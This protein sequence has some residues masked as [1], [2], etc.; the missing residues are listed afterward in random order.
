M[1]MKTIRNFFLTVFLCLALACVSCNPSEINPENPEDKTEDVGPY[2]AVAEFTVPAGVRSVYVEYPNASGDTVFKEVSV[3]PVVAAP[4]GG[5]D[6]EPFG[7]VKLQVVSE[8]K[9][10]ASIY[11]RTGTPTKAADDDDKVYTVESLQVTKHYSSSAP[12][13]QTSVTIEE[14]A[15]YTTEDGG[16]SFYHSSGVVMFDDSWPGAP[17][18]TTGFIADYNDVVVDYDFEARI[19]SDDMLAEEGWREQLKVVLHIRAVGGDRPNRVGLIMENFDTRY[20]D[21]NDIELHKSLD[22]YMNPHGELPSSF[23]RRIGQNCIHDESNPTRPWIEI[24]GLHRLNQNLSE[25]NLSCEEYTYTNY[26][27]NG[28][29]V[30]TKHVFNPSFGYWSAPDQSQYDPEIKRKAQHYYNAIPGYVNVHGGL[31]TITVIYHKLPR[32]EMSPEESEAAKQNMIDAVM[33]TTNQNFYI[34]IM[35]YSEIGL[36]GYQP[37]DSFKS[38]YNSVVAGSSYLTDSNYYTGSDGQVWG[39]KAPVMT[40]H[41]WEKYPLSQAYPQFKDW[42]AGD[43]AASGWYLNYDSKYLCCEW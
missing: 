32:A 17:S 19:A 21:L 34:M 6:V 3:T 20:I 2:F 11:F 1:N 36:K 41:L 18:E 24:G 29:L 28:N 33:N 35:D 27:E 23:E 30:S 16:M 9:A 22:S 31:I 37:R 5:R 42:I 38:K 10:T 25:A 7:T 43:A 14:P 26:D 12:Q 8:T 15:P 4:S 40:R 13:A 39:I